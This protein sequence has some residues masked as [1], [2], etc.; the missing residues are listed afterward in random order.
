MEDILK[1]ENLSKA[2]DTFRVDKISFNLPSGSIMGF[3]GEN[4][5]GKTT[6][7]KAILNLIKKDG[8]TVKLFGKELE[9]NEQEIK[10]QI[11][12]VMEECF[13]PFAFK[14]PEVSLVMRNIF[15]TWD[16]PLFQR[17]LDKFE[18][19]RGKAI[20]DY[21]KGMRMKLF[22]STA[23]AHHPRLLIL[24]EATSGLDPIVRN[25]IL[26]E[27]L[28]FIQDEQHSIL[29]S[30]H[31]TSDLEKIA[32]YITFIH[33]GRILY[34]GTKDHLIDDYGIVKCT[35]ENLDKL[36]KKDI[37]AYR[38]NEFG[39]EILVNDKRKFLSQY[40]GYTVD[41]ATIEQIMLFLTKGE[42]R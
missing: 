41:S 19:P 42:Q 38:N 11:G 34:K 32:D 1:V 6:T 26:D 20:K 17:Y 9:G 35:K 37:K 23:M 33:Q 36:D 5:A 39:C 8:G 25:E 27:F 29:L 10:E 16:E 15:K 24:D 18:L 3:V 7:L 2:Y 22:I 21:S 4:G 28:D 30:T 14:P 31:I 13:F 12:M 40:R